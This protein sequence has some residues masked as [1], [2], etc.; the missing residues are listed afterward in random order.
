M[1]Q[2]FSAEEVVKHNTPESCWVALYGN[3]W[4]VTSFL[5]SHPGGS[6][7]ILK[8]AGRD[9]TEEY[10]P[11]HPPG[12]LEEN[13]PPTA[14]LGIYDASTA[15][16]ITK[17]EDEEPKEGS[18]NMQNLLN[19][20]EI[21]EVATKQISK[22]SQ[23]PSPSAV[24]KARD[25]PGGGVG[26]S[27]FFGTAA[28][29]TWKDTLKWLEQQTDLP[30]VLKGL[31]THEDAYMAA[32]FPQVKAIIL[33][34]H[35]GRA[36]DTAP[37]AV[38]TLLE[39][40]KYCPEVFSRL[41]VWVD[42]GIKRGTDVVKALC[43]GAKAVG[44]GRAAL[45][46]LGAG[47]TEGVERTF[48]I[49]KAEIDTC[50][51]LLGVDKVSDLG[52]K[53]VIAFDLSWL[54]NSQYFRNVFA[55]SPVEMWWKSLIGRHYQ[56]HFS[57]HLKTLHRSTSLGGQNF[58][59]CC[60]LAVNASLTLSPDGR[61]IK[62]QTDYI[63]ATIEEF[64]EA[65]NADQFPCT[66]E[67]NGDPRGAPRVIVTSGW[68]EQT[69]PGWSLSDSKKGD[70]SEWVN[71][72]IGFIIPCIIFVLVIPRRRKLAVWSR[73]FVQDLSQIISWIVAPFAMILSGLAVCLDTIIWLCVCFAFAGPMILS[74][75][76]EAYLDQ[77][78]IS[79]LNEKTSN[80]RLTI[81]MRARLLFVVLVGNLDLDPEVF[82]GDE[83]LT[84]LNHGRHAD[85]NPRW[86]NYPGTQTRNPSSP[87]KW[88]WERG[89]S[90]QDWIDRV[91]STYRF[92]A[93]SGRRGDMVVDEDME[94]LRVATT[95]TITSW[96]ITSQIVLWMWA[97]SGPPQP[98]K[99]FKFF[100]KDGYLYRS[101]FYNPTDVKSL[102]QKGKFW[103]LKSLWAIIWYN[104]AAIFGLGGVITS[105]GGT[106]MQLMGV[107]ST[108]KCS[109]NAEY[110]TKPH[111]QVPV[112]LSKNYALEIADAKKYWVPS[113]ITA[114][115][116]LALVTFCGWWYQR[117][118]R[119][120][121]RNLVSELG[122]ERTDREDIRAIV[123]PSRD[124]DE[125]SIKP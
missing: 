123:T 121:F 2:K 93:P 31:Q 30:I 122:S 94:A 112:V 125:E 41:E 89:R 47:G 65:N 28:D 110:W 27:L 46:G 71:P 42:G 88:L 40:R 77:K 53:H 80:F 24:K 39:I 68:Q 119:G 91:I 86:P 26:K 32:Q 18:P 4:D 76:Y 8:L 23:L 20:D 57:S 64:L 45:F 96:T 7:I 116:F 69:C 118:L 92:R 21:E 13:L 90:K 120:M 17:P 51:R 82:A 34:N 113:A 106:M 43:L 52:P 60:L 117:R 35:G 10:D 87:P 59:H 33:S 38:H 44:V 83:E 11:I 29:L 114:I 48:E 74:G 75:F 100:R 104:L 25:G 15:P 58:T 5:P 56:P 85:D 79:F 37:P 124:G 101:G 97:Y 108:P 3:V 78:V 115:L 9:C 84:V 16:E 67:W 66:A 14:K 81:D 107:Y 99:W 105:I 95:M 1:S 111:S 19:L 55:D 36:L 61:L 54:T 50:M 62:S 98:G 22:K 72:F 70:E 73:L 49:L 102:W 6:A 103:S 63:D 109:V 12:T